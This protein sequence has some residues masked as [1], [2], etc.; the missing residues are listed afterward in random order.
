MSAISRIKQVT[1]L[2]TSD[3][4]LFEGE[5]IEAAEAHQKELDF[6]DAYEASSEKFYGDDTTLCSIDPRD[7]LGWI[8]ANRSV[9]QD[10]LDVTP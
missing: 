7:L 6:I 9:V 10:L 8:K 5:E 4:M 1:R 3:G 2:Q